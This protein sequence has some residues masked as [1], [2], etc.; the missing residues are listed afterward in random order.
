MT[1]HDEIKTSRHGLSFLLAKPNGPEN[2]SIQKEIGQTIKSSQ[3]S[4]PIPP[5]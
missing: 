5:K 1:D 4:I 3:I 2:N